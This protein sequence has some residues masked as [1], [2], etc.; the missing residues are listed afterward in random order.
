M[1]RFNSCHIHICV[2]RSVALYASLNYANFSHGNLYYGNL[3]QYD[4]KK[5]YIDIASSLCAKQ[6]DMIQIR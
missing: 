5:K 2:C 1:T 3:K 6:D 4:I